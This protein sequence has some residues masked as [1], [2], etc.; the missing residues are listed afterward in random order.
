MKKLLYLLP[1]LLLTACGGGDD[2]GETPPPAPDPDPVASVHCSI[3]APKQGATVNPKVAL[4]IRGEGSANYCTLGEAQLKIG[5][6]VIADVKSVPFTYQHT[7]PSN[8]AEGPLTISLLV[9]N[10]EKTL[11]A[12]ST[13]TVTLKRPEVQRPSGVTYVV[14]KDGTGD[15]DSVQKAIDA[16]KSNQSDRQV[17]YIK[18]GTY[19]EKMLVPSNKTNITLIGEDAATTILT[20]D[21]YAGKPLDTGGELGTQNSASFT[22][23]GKDFTAQNLTFQ[24]PHKNLANTSGNHQAVAVC[25]MDDRATFYNC[26]MVGYQ[27]T[28]YVKNHARVYCKECYIEGNVDF[29]FGDAI[30]LCENCTLHCN[31]HDSVLTAA[32]EHTGCAFGFTF[33]DCKITHIEGKD[34]NNREFTTFYLGRPWKQNARVVFIRCE[35]PAKLNEKAWR[36]MSEGVDAALFAEYKCTGAG[37]APERLSKREMGGRQLTDEEASAYTLQNIFAKSTYSGFSSDWTPPTKMAIQ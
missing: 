18:S 26:R 34:F 25:V 35:E 9:K 6:S 14:A 37:A 30:L 33:I 3:T 28:F 2:G 7:F 1:W 12:S 19:H 4:E 32:A 36:R 10:T 13:I 17:I 24:N 23:K 31:R 15:Y 27:D 11:S 5:Q 16:L 29:I 8:Q 22:I 20:Y 21:D